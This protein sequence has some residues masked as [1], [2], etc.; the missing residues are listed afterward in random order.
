MG[1]SRYNK[2][3]MDSTKDKIQGETEQTEQQ[4]GV[5]D[6]ERELELLVARQRVLKYIAGIPTE[7]A[8]EKKERESTRIRKERFLEVYAQTAGI[9]TVACEKAGIGRTQLY[10][11][12]NT[13][14]EFKSKLFDVET[15]QLDMAEDRLLK[16]IQQDDGPSVRYF[17]DRRHPKY[18]P[19]S[20]TTLVLGKTFTQML[21]EEGMRR[22]QQAIKG[23][24]I[25]PKQLNGPDNDTNKQ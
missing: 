17:L 12:I 6:V 15:S 1:L 23:E 24:V 11:W 8:K 14:P 22:R 20:E 5:L 10:E 16:L 25:E 13:D 2:V 18:K 21:W 7:E 4:T 3:Q 19:T 9:K